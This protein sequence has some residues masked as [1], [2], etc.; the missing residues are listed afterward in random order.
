[1]K[2]KPY[3]IPFTFSLLLAYSCLFAQN[4]IIWGEVPG[5]ISMANLDGSAVKNILQ[6][7]APVDLVADSVGQ[8]V[9]WTDNANNVI[10][11]TGLDD[12]E[13]VK[14]YQAAASLQGLT[15]DNNQLYFVAGTTIAKLNLSNQKVETLVSSVS[16]IDVVVIDERVYWSEAG[17]LKR[18]SIDGQHTEVVLGKLKQA[19]TLVYNAVDQKL[20]FYDNGKIYKVNP[21]G[22]QLE[23]VVEGS[24]FSLDKTGRKLLLTNTNLT[25]SAWGGVSSINTDGSNRQ[26]VAGTTINPSNVVSVGDKIFWL[27]QINGY[28]FLDYLF[29]T[30]PSS[31]NEVR[32]SSPINN[33]THLA[34]DPLAKHIYWV[35]NG[36]T[37]KQ[38]NFS[39][40]DIQSLYTF[41]ASQRLANLALDYKNK[42]FYWTNNHATTPGI[43][44]MN[45][46]GSN[47]E[48]L[49]PQAFYPGPG[50]IAIRPDQNQLYWSDPTARRITQ[51]ELNG[52]NAEV[53]ELPAVIPGWLALDQTGDNLFFTSRLVEGGHYIF[54]MP[55]NGGNVENLYPFADTPLSFCM[56]AQNGYFYWTYDKNIMRADLNGAN[57]KTILNARNG[58]PNRYIG[59]IQVYHPEYKIVVNDSLRTTS[60]KKLS[61]NP[62]RDFLRIEDLEEEDLV[63]VYNI[64]GQ[65]YSSQKVEQGGSITILGQNLPIGMA[66]LYIRSKN[67]K[68][69]VAKIYKY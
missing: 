36:T 44:R 11:S 40:D 56:D 8:R 21:D 64:M 49:S 27:D 12:K 2:L 4:K 32:A 66:Y 69:S 63:Q 25:H 22:S 41:P 38:T 45:V 19:G 37:I 24:Y 5:K 16:A 13:V 62:F 34:I 60:F 42:K 15:I 31:G 53:T 28:N 18:L 68:V 61:P 50:G 58:N 65:L 67:G 48:N 55:S 35:E 23:F 43:F 1:M 29:S 39:G 17:A 51:A 3:L 54:K 57:V 46:D 9:F 52:K 47:L 33:P 20:Y 30:K 10:F 26:H 14:V 7:H 6:K 59:P